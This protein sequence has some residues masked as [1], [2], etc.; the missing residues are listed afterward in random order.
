MAARG[1]WWDDDASTAL[2]RFSWC[3]S[4]HSGCAFCRACCWCSINPY[5]LA[6]TPL[7]SPRSYWLRGDSD[8][9]QSPC[10][11]TFVQVVLWCV[12]RGLLSGRGGWRMASGRGR[13]LDQHR[14]AEGRWRRCCGSVTVGSFLF[15]M[16]PGFPSCLFSLP[17]P[18]PQQSPSESEFLRALDHCLAPTPALHLASVI[19]TTQHLQPLN[20]PTNTSNHGFQWLWT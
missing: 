12:E 5:Y 15:I 13:G 19:S 11:C 7:L 6:W 8:A 3:W 17:C 1:V 14:A 18:A 20:D 16:S 9:T 10:S 4:P 2:G